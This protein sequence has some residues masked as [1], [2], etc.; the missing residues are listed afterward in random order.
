MN[1]QELIEQYKEYENAL[2]DIGAKL[3]C[4]SF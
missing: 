1:I 4:Q 3:A 2:Y